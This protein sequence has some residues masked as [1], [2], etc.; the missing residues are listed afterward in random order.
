MNLSSALGKNRDCRCLR[1]L[2]PEIA[3]Y[4]CSKRKNLAGEVLVTVK[5]ITGMASVAVIQFVEARLVEDCK[6]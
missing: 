1:E 2:C 6:M 4:G 5:A 3:I